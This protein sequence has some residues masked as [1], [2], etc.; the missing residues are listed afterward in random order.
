MEMD[1]FK[2]IVYLLCIAASLTCTLLLLRAY[3]QNRV[4]LLL[5][6]GLCFIGLTVNN[7]VLFLDTVIFPDN[8][9]Y[10]FR[11]TATVMGILCLLYGF[12]W[13]SE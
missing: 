13:E 9:L 3:S 7:I 10:M 4:R 5:W 12:I 6:S 2:I 8:D 11:M 1:V